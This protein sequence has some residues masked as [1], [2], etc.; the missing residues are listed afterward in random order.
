VRFP[1]QERDFDGMFDQMEWLS[2]RTDALSAEAAPARRAE[3]SA[4]DGG[5][6]RKS[7][8]WQTG[9]QGVDIDGTEQT[10]LEAF[11]DVDD[12]FCATRQIRLGIQQDG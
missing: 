6:E 11:E 10:S 2:E 12:R 5:Y 3:L 4:F 1:F 7:A 8:S 9:H